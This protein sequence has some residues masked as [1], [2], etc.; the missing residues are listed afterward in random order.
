VQARYHGPV[1]N[2]SALW[3]VSIKTVLF[4]IGVLI[5]LYLLYELRAVVVQ[6]LL[7]IIVSAGMTPI[8]DRLAPAIDPKPRALTRRR[9]APRALIVVG[10]YVLLVV[11]I[12]LLAAILV[13]PTVTQVE[14]LVNNLPRYADA[15][16]EWV[17]GLP[18]KYPFLPAG[19]GDGLPQQL[20]GGAA[21]LAGF[22]SQAL[23]VFRLLLSVL[24]GALNF[25]FVLFLALYLTADAD[26]V[27]RW[28]VNWLPPDRRSQ[29]DEVLGHIGVKLGGWVRGQLL[30]SGII[31]GITLVGLLILGVPYAVLL[32]LVA[33]VGEAVPMVGPIFSA[34]PAVI[35]A[36]FVSPWLGVLTILLYI[37][38]QQVENA[39]VVPKVME[40][41]VSLHPLAVMLALLIGGELYGVSGAILSVP[42]AAAVSVVL[43]EVKRERDE[44]DIDKTGLILDSAGNGL[45]DG[46]PGD[47]EATPTIANDSKSSSAVP[48]SL[49]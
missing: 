32:S 37:V 29:V 40:R 26:R 49:P 41:A 47:T 19:L 6:L 9:S 30:L 24:G 4:T 39:V 27:R 46:S 36:F 31:G 17:K 44:A 35:I 12:A 8:V 2:E 42:V 22:L 1:V 13:P 43:A 38:I 11:T 7:A 21:Q 34:V 10:L 25:I 14:E 18:A 20:E 16:Q 28:T 15:F 45:V 3:R 5:G 23:V 48:S 33:A